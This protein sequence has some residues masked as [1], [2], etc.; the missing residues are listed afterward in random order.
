M[1]KSD[2]INQLTAIP[3]DPDVCITDLVKNAND[4]DNDASANGIYAD[5]DV[6]HLKGESVPETAKEFI[7]LSFTTNSI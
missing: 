2:L 3:G 5:F 6:E 1:K 4:V 7:S